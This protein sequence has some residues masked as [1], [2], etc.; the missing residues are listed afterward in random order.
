MKRGSW[1]VLA[2]VILASVC[3]GAK[4]GYKNS[5]ATLALSFSAKAVCSCLFVSGRTE[6]QCVEYADLGE[7]APKAKFSV[8]RKRQRVTASLFWIL[9]QTARYEGPERGCRLP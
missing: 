4:K 6:A 5:K 9:R 2:A 8:D 3:L 1:L 7:G